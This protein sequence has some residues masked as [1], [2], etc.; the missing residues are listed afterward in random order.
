MAAANGVPGILNKIAEIDPP[1]EPPTK[2]A[3]RK[4]IAGTAGKLIATGSNRIIP[5]RGPSPGMAPTINPTIIP[6]KVNIK[7]NGDVKTSK[8]AEKNS[9]II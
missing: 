2:I 4:P 3:I 9:K 6:V 7:A 5:M 8:P 1:H